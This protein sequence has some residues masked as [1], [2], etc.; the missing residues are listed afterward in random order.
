ME[1]D[2]SNR[3]LAYLLLVSL[4]I[5]IIGTL[6]TLNKIGGF[7][8]P[9]ITGSATSGAG[10]TQLQVASQLMIS[11]VD[12]AINYGTCTPNFTYIGG[13]NLSSVFDSNDTSKAGS[14]EGLCTNLTNPHNITLENGGN[15]NANVTVKIDNNQITGGYNQ[16][17]Y[18]AFLNATNAPGCYK[19]SLGWTNFTIANTEYQSC[20]NLSYPNK[21][22][23]YFLRLYAPR[24]STAGTKS[25]ILTFTAY[26]SVY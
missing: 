10:T 2:F 21:R 26:N 9:L 18:F 3:T 7:G 25:A 24:D 13:S 20:Q 22:V 19:G 4:F 23:W 6:I 17:I 8:V 15:C 5:S 11:V 12:G 1:G 14:G 16:S